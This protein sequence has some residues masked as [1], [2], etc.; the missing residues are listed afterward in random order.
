M[1]GGAFVEL[2]DEALDVRSDDAVVMPVGVQRRVV[3]DPAAG[4]VA[5]VAAPT[6]ARAS[7]QGGGEPVLPAWIA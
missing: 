5:V 7:V 4:F 3:A 2:D 1:G 6:G